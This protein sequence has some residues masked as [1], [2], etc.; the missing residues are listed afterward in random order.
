M[1]YSVTIE[2]PIVFYG[3]L[4]IGQALKTVFESE[5]F[6]VLGFIDQRADELPKVLGKPVETLETMSYAKECV[7]VIT[8]KNVFQH[9][10]IANSLIRKGYTQIIFFPLDQSRQVIPEYEDILK[11]YNMIIN[12]RYTKQLPENLDNFVVTEVNSV[13]HPRFDPYKYVESVGDNR[14]VLSVPVEHIYSEIQYED[15]MKLLNLLALP[16]VDLFNFYLNSSISS[17]DRYITYNRSTM[18]SQNFEPTE[19][20]L[21]SSLANR[22]DIC[23]RMKQQFDLNPRFFIES[24]QEAKWDSEKNCFTVNGGRHRLSFL[25]SQ[26]KTIVP[27]SVSKECLDNYLNLDCVEA[28]KKE[29]NNTNYRISEPIPHPAFYDITAKRPLYNQNVYLKTISFIMNWMFQKKGELFPQITFLNV[30]NEYFSLARFFA[31]HGIKCAN[32]NSDSSMA[33]LSNSILRFDVVKSTIPDVRNWY[34][35][36]FISLDEEEKISEFLELKN[37]SFL[38]YETFDNENV[39]GNFLIGRDFYKGRSVYLMGVENGN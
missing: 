9:Y 39:S 18:I 13:I 33:K 36:I 29:L 17:L 10:K 35:V 21:E 12:S 22:F 3:A 34:D 14:Y 5:G 20:W 6:T 16:H 15:K 19:K 26:N 2:T 8:I 25:I 38:I 4:N 24:A 7:V 27:L 11:L 23:A 37:F 1:S 31:N 28:I 32:A 30:S